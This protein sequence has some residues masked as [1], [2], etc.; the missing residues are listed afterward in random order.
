MTDAWLV[1]GLTFLHGKAISYRNPYV[2]K[3][4]TGAPHY[5]GVSKHR[6]SILQAA[7]RWLPWITEDNEGLQKTRK[8]QGLKPK[9]PYHGLKYRGFRWAKAPIVTDSEQKGS[10]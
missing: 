6:T 9:T 4:Q 7:L 2:I 10:D 8:G 5:Q 1:V 3:V